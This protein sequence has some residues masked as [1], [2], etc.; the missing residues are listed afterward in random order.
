MRKKGQAVTLGKA[1]M[2]ILMLGLAVLIAAASGIALNSFKQTECGDVWSGS[3]C[4]ND[5]TLVY[6]S[7]TYA[8]NISFFGEQ[9]LNN[10]AIQIPTVGTVI[11]V[12][13]I[14]MV[15]VGAFV[16]M[17]RKQAL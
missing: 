5:S 3:E 2:V 9:G 14:I 16:F 6:R 11:G 13:L 1:P 7:G 8:A 12:A 4:Y 15:I 10:W 17:G